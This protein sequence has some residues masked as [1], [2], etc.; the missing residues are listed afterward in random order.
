MNRQSYFSNEKIGEGFF[1][2]FL[3]QID[4]VASFDFD[5]R[6]SIQSYVLVHIARREDPRQANVSGPINGD[7]TRLTSAAKPG[8][9]YSFMS[10][11]GRCPGDVAGR[12][13]GSMSF[14]VK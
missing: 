10:I 8:D 11:K 2:D 7:A 14:F 3:T 6:C 12:E 5:A 9:Q 1:Q 13:L 4:P